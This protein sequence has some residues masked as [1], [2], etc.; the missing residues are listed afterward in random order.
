VHP[1]LESSS[2]V[3]GKSSEN[4]KPANFLRPL[5]QSL[6]TSSLPSYFWRSLASNLSPRVQEIM[7]RGGVSAR[8]LRSNKD[9]VRD[10]V[11]ECV[12]RGSQLPAGPLSRGKTVMTGSWEREAAVMV[13]SIIGVMGR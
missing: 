13:G 12:N 3:D 11:R 1:L 9:R 5:L 4:A 6:D 8:T 7:H 10:A 2:L